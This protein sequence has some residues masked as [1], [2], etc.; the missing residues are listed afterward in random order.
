MPSRHKVVRETQC[1]AHETMVGLV[2]MDTEELPTWEDIVEPT[3]EE[4]MPSPRRSKPAPAW[5]DPDALAE[6]FKI[7]EPPSVQN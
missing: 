4:V 1:K 5:V 2:K 7:I 3:L 6:F